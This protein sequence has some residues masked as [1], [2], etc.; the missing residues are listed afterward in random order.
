VATELTYSPSPSPVPKAR[1]RSSRTTR[2]FFIRGLKTLLPTLIT[3]SLIVWVWDFLW[4]Q[5]GRHLIWVVQNA[6]YQLGG[7]EAQWGQIRRDWMNDAGTDWS[8]QAQVVGVSLSLLLVY[9]VGLFVGNLIGRTFWVVG[10]SLAMRVPVVRAIYPAVKQVTDFLL[11]DKRESS[12]FAN[13]RVVACRPHANGIWSIG[14]IT[15]AGLPS[16]NERVASE[17]GG[18]AKGTAGGESRGVDEML[19]VFVPS[20]PTAFSGYVMIVPRSQVVELPMTVDQAMRLLI[21]GG[22]INPEAAP[23]APASGTPAPATAGTPPATRLA[24]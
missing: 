13:S 10:E 19:T 3:L 11:A 5:L 22:V 9:F 20:S 2:T 14:L 23:A 12:Q 1:G 6:Q 24:S 16:L 7:P 17:V 8:W 18:G 15:G 21:S 4:N